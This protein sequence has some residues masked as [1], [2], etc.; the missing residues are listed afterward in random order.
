MFVLTPGQAADCSQFQAVLERIRVPGPRGR[1]RTRPGA[2]AADRAYSSRTNRVYLR[3]RGV[4]AVI[5]EKTDQA[6][7]RR[8]KGSAG[9]RPVAFDA[10][11]Y[12]QRNT[13]ERS[14]SGVDSPLGTTN[15]PRASR[16]DFTS[17]DQSCG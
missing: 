6:A 9:G 17:E 2:V 5:P 15:L 10:Q 3:G 1:P 16:Q 12:R 7:N 4:T 11:R 14:R 8:R 13:V